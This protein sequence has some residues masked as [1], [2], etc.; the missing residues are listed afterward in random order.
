MPQ[1]AFTLKYLCAEFN[2]VFSNGKVNRIIQP[3]ND[4]IMLTV[5][6]SKKCTKK[7]LI[8]VNP[9]SPRISICNQEKDSPLTAPN[10]CML[11]RKH[12]LSATILGVELVGFDRI[13]KID[14]LSCGEFFDA[15]KKTL[16]IE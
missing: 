12:L 2:E 16:Y 8:N 4:E 7:M 1:D 13:V 15:V 5:Y 14:F 11:M 3:S 6:T 9:S 10:F